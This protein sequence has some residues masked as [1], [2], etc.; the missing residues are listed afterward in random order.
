LTDL[1]EF[2][3]DRL[4]VA[5]PHFNKWIDETL[6]E[7]RE[8]SVTVANLQ[9]P[10]LGRLFAASSLEEARVTV[11]NGII[12]RPRLA[13][14]GLPE[15]WEFETLE[16]AGITYKNHYFLSYTYESERLHFHEMVHTVQWRTLGPDRFLLAYGLGLSLQ[17]YEASPLEQMAS[18][19]E[20]KF[21][22]GEL[23]G[24]IEESI[25]SQTIAIWQQVAPLVDGRNAT[26]WGRGSLA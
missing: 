10:N 19:L 16:I 5:L 15:F 7:Y 18:K 25:V 24:D 8:Q 2:P 12:P 17:G 4:A 1:E 26:T 22:R 14:W 23:T 21:A 11:T 9:L 20:S 6:Q 3:W 13:A